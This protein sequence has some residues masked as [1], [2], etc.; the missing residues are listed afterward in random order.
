MKI[1]ALLRH[2]KSSWDD[3]ALRDFDRP[4]K[5]RG[6]LASELIGKE[7]GRRGLEFDL[8][9]ASPALRVVETLECLK[10]GLGVPLHVRFMEAIYGQS[11]DGLM[12][13]LR[14]LEDKAERVL[15]VGHN[16]GLQELSLALAVETDPMLTAVAELYPTAALAILELPTNSWTKLRPGTGRITDFLQPRHFIKSGVQPK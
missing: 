12:E 16:P 5:R 6:R 13:I 14:N 3:P 1:L 7:L 8:V 15:L 2:G 9:L 10:E 11:S 4:L